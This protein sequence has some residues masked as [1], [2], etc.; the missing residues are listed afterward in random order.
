MVEEVLAA[1]GIEVNRGSGRQWALKFCQS[2]AN[3]IRRGF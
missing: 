3:W 1:R 2:F